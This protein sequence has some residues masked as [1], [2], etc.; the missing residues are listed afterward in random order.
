MKWVTLLQVRIYTREW[1]WYFNRSHFG[2]NTRDPAWL[3]HGM[4]N[5]TEDD[6]RFRGMKQEKIADCV[7]RHACAVILP[8]RI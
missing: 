8:K 7:L 1:E 2:Q 3:G 4:T 6:R 5:G